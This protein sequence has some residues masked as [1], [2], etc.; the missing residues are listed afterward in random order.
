MITLRNWKSKK[1]KINKNSRIKGE[2]KK[3]AKKI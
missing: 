3:I 1:L 2:N